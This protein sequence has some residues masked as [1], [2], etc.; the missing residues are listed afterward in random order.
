MYALKGK[1]EYED[2]WG[3]YIVSLV[4]LLGYCTS[5]KD[6]FVYLNLNRVSIK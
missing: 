2:L 1:D 3:T 4:T 5:A 6:I